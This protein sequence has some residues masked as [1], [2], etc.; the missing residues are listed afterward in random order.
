MYINSNDASKL[1][2]LSS[3]PHMFQIFYITFV[4]FFMIL[5]LTS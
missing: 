4:S 1:R 5:P 2:K 3:S